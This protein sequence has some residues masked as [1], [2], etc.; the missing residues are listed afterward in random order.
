M[1]K[2]VII[3]AKP[4]TIWVCAYTD[5]GA[6]AGFMQI[7]STAYHDDGFRRGM[8]FACSLQLGGGWKCAGCVAAPA[9]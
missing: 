5:Y 3:C 2:R 4:R 9:Q 7:N 8:P 1:P 6:Y